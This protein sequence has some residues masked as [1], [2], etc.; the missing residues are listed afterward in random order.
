[1]IDVGS[2]DGVKV[3]DPVVNADGLVGEVNAVTG[4]ASQGEADHRP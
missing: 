2:S 4:G 3:H 1:M